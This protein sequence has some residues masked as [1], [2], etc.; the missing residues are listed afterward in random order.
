MC[1]TDDNFLVVTRR[2]IVQMIIHITVALLKVATFIAI[3]CHNLKLLFKVGNLVFLKP[4]VGHVLYQC[5]N[6]ILR[7]I[8]IL[9]IIVCYC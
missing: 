4:K 7:G 8:F 2:Q 1:G 3:S 6:K 9:F 5:L